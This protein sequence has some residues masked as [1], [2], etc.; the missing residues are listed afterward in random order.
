MGHFVYVLE[1]EESGTYYVGA[2]SDPDRRCAH[3][4]STS[5]GF[6][7]RYRPWRLVFTEEFATKEAARAAERLIKGWKSRKMTRYVVEGEIDLQK[8]LK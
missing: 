3:H 4:N 2:S 1:S 6:T 7:A 5:T 8:R